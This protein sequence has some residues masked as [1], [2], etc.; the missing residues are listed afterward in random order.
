MTAHARLELRIDELVCD[1]VDPS[2]RQRFGHALEQNLAQLIGER[3]VPASLTESRSIRAIVTPAL[4]LPAG[5]T[6][7]VVARELASVIYDG[8]SR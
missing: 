1:G 5:A 6:L 4:A 2:N 8:L 3:G 7:E